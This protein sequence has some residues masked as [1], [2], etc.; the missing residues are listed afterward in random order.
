MNYIGIDTETIAKNA[1]ELME[2]VRVMAHE[3]HITQ[4]A[5]AIA[6]LTAAVLDLDDTVMQLPCTW[7]RYD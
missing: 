3:N 4:E 2:A 6:Y 1:Q 7:N 5:A